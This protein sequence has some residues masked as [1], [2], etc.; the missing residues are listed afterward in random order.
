M[1]RGLKLMD[2]MDLWIVLVTL[3]GCEVQTSCH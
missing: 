2:G 1:Q 3:A